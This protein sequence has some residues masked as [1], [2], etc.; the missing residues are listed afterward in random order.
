MSADNV[1]SDAE[2]S[3]DEGGPSHVA[4]IAAS[5]LESLNEFNDD[6]VVL[7]K[8]IRDALDESTANA[9]EQAPDGDEWD[10]QESLDFE[11]AENELTELVSEI[12]GQGIPFARTMELSERFSADR[13]ERI[14]AG[15]TPMTSHELRLMAD[16]CNPELRGVNV[17]DPWTIGMF[18]F[19]PE[20]PFTKR[21][22]M[23]AKAE[24]ERRIAAGIPEPLETEDLVKLHA[25]L[26]AG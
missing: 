26:N 8:P 19:L 7:T 22:L 12:R 11:N 1:E 16:V 5:F 2:S 14:A 9:G 10:E 17:D 20:V 25:E 4:W 6:D 24:R 23:A 21:L 15:R 3:S 13:A 18:E